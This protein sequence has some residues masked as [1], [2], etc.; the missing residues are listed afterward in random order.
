M[1]PGGP[2]GIV[3]AGAA[4]IG[5]T[6]LAGEVL[7]RARGRGRATAWV[8][9]TRSAGSIPFGAFAHL[10]P[11]AFGAGRPQNLLRAAGESIAGR[12]ADGSLVLAV[13]DAH[14]LDAAS[15]ALVRH[16][17]ESAAGFV[18]ATVRSNEPAPD[19]IGSL[20]KDGPVRRIELPSLS[21][22]ELGA[23]L[24]VV[25]EAHVDGATVHRLW[26]ASR[27]N[28]LYVAR[29]RARGRGRRHPGRVARLVALAWALVRGDPAAGGADR[30]TPRGAATGG[31]RGARDRRPEP[32]PWRERSWT[33]SR[34]P[35]TARGSS[36]EDCSRP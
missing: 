11:V 13:D 10:L 25:M 23:L 20:W 2:A 9:A 1:E 17:T 33:P 15:A 29:A 14:L 30:R 19:A 6:R 32:S 24:R 31:A 26:E 16:L 4:G 35:P 5:K 3:L 7:R 12:A 8:Q 28:V 22:D 36:V 21:E 34:R 27:G 18:V